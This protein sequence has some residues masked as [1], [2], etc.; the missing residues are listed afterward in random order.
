[1]VIRPTIG[2]SPEGAALPPD[3]P[4]PEPESPPPQAARSSVAVRPVASAAARRP[5]GEMGFLA[6]VFRTER[7][8]VR[9]DR[10]GIDNVDGGA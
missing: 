4:E 8:L 6:R 9:I 1:L 7:P 10:V 5:P 2:C 3:P